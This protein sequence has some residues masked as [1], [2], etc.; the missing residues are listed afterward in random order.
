MFKKYPRCIGFSEQN[1][2]NSVETFLGLGFN[3]DEVMMMVKC[4]PPCH[5]LPAESIKRKTEFLV[6]K[7]NW[8]REGV[9]LIPVV[10]GCS[11]VNRILPRCNVIK[12]LMSKRLLKTKVSSMSSVLMRCFLKDMWGS[13]MTACGWVYG[14]FH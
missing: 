7:M 14:Y 1:I 3:K 11:M 13:M 4:Y 8:L 2:L 5:N 6:K 9:L 12:A 10:L